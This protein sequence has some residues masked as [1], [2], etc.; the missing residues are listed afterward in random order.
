M[1]EEKILGMVTKKGKL[2]KVRNTYVVTV[3]R[4]RVQVPVGEIIAKAD[5]DKMV[6]KEVQVAISGGKKAAIVGIGLW[7]PAGPAPCYWIICYIPVPDLITQIGPSIRESLVRTMVSEKIITEEFA[8]EI[9]V[10][11]RG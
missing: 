9:N 11:S 6:G 4:K 8:K 5:L 10:G 3:D 2:S 1:P 7:P